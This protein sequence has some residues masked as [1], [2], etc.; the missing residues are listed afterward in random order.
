[1]RAVVEEEISRPMLTAGSMI[2]EF[3][4]N[5]P[6]AV[7][8]IEGFSTARVLDDTGRFGPRGQCWDLRIRTHT[9]DVWTRTPFGWRR[10]SHETIRPE[11]RTA[12][13]CCDDAES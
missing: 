1:M 7:C 10:K 12:L 4:V 5:G 11:R 6:Q 9:R 2:A 3:Q 8:E 13:A